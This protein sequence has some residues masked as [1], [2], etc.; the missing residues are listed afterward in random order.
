MII[1]IGNI[2]ISNEP[3]VSREIYQTVCDELDTCITSELG[4]ASEFDYTGRIYDIMDVYKIARLYGNTIYMQDSSYK[5]PTLVSLSEFIEANSISTKPYVVD[6]F[7]CEN[8]AIDLLSDVL[9]YYGNVPFGM[10]KIRGPNGSHRLNCAYIEGEWYWVEPQSDYLYTELDDGYE[11]V[12]I[13][14]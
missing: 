4:T 7:D 1:T 3:V 11:V 9:N 6:E 12:F 8:Y 5:E 10:A 14:I 2:T 13:M